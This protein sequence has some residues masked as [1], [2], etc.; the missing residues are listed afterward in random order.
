MLLNL[1]SLVVL[2]VI[3]PCFNYLRFMVLKNLFFVLWFL[4]D[5]TYLFE[6]LML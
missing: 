4:F 1:F 5:G 2:D 3:E 6:V